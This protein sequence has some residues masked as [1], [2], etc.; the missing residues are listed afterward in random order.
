MFFSEP[1]GKAL[2]PA[3]G[4]G[5]TPKQGFSWAKPHGNKPLAGVLPRRGRGGRDAKV[6]ENTGRGIGVAPKGVGFTKKGVVKGT[7]PVP[8]MLGMEKREKGGEKRGATLV[9][10]TKPVPRDQGLV[11]GEW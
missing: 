4:G 1:F 11:W 5:T 2:T 3:R 8:K 9:G 6:V 10:N 7:K